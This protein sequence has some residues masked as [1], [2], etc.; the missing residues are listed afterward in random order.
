MYD[1][2]FK[3]GKFF[4]ADEQNPYCSVIGVKDGRISYTGDTVPDNCGNC[5]I[6][7]L[8]GR[9]VIPGIIDNHIHPRYLADALEQIACLPPAIN[10]IEE[11][12]AEIKK[13]AESQPKGTWIVGWGYSEDAFDEKRSP[14]RYDLDEVAPDHPVI[15]YRMCFHIVAVNSKTLEIAGIDENTPDEEGSV[16]ERDENGVPT[17]ILKEKIRFELENYRE[18]SP[19][20]IQRRLLNLSDFLLSQGITAIAD[21]SGDL[22][23]VNCF[24]MYNNVRKLGFKQR[25]G[26]YYVWEDLKKSGIEIADSQKDLSQDI[27]IAGVKLI[28][29]GSLS[30]RTAWSDK[31]YL[32]DSENYG[33]P[34]ASENDY[35]EAADFARKNNLQLKCHAMGE[36][37]IERIASIFEGN[38]S[39]LD[40]GRPSVRI[41]HSAMP[42]ED[43]LNKI[44]KS[45]IAMTV[46]PLFVFAEID[47]YITALGH[48]RT[49]ATYPVVTML[50]KGILTAFSSDA[51]ATLWPAPSDPFMGMQSAVTRVARDGTDVGQN[52]K[53]DIETALNLYTRESQKI[54]GFRDI[55]ILKEGCHADFVVLDRDITEID[56]F[57]IGNTKVSQVYMDGELVFENKEL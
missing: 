35:I 48:E 24:D 19:E 10:S 53:V 2:I 51:P 40:D 12:K 20:E 15:L 11:L 44:A 8:D 38:A 6:V 52:E 17:G 54:M 43:S 57:D 47:N 7:D 34:T 26:I 37:T 33:L 32:D 56:S 31:P 23:P 42:L 9:R 49:K 1:I 5:R 55:G 14:N 45:G 21:S 25:I 36:R 18:V 13:R 46:Q 27:F 28:G 4:T 30:G 50:D 3:E 41:E 16:I 29:D 39:W 22:E